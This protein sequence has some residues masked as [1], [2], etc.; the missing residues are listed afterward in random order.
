ME[1]KDIK[2]KVVDKKDIKGLLEHD[3]VQSFIASSKKLYSQI[4]KYCD[5]NETISS[6]IIKVRQ[7]TKRHKKKI[8]SVIV[9]LLAIFITVNYIVPLK[10][11]ASKRQ[12]T[13]RTDVWKLGTVDFV[14][15]LAVMGLVRGGESVDVGFQVAGMLN[16]V[17]V[18]EGQMVNKGDL[19]VTLDPTDARLKVEYNES[20]LKAAQ[21]RVEVHEQLFKLKNI[22]A[23]KLDEVK[24]EYE[25]QLK[26]LEFAR[27]E[28]EKTRLIAPVSGLVGPIEVEPGELVTPNTKVSSLYNVSHV[29]VDLGIIEKDIGKI[30]IGQKIR[31]SV[32]A[33]PDVI[34][35]GKLITISP[36][37]EGKSRNFKV[38]AKLDNKNTS[39][40][41][42]PGMFVRA[43]LEVFSAEKSLVIPVTALK[44]NKVYVLVDGKA[45]A[46]EVKIVYRSY[47]YVVIESGLG[48]G[49]VIVAELEGDFSDEPKIEIINEREYES[50]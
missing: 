26:E 20:K 10:S 36:V 48:A 21:K 16:E 25:S 19:L 45:K 29:Y 23:A 39:A 13:V 32:D 6:F 33:Y 8:V 22:I 1:D 17:L 27:R 40:L 49:D 50:S 7:I 3:K 31:A 46:K 38:T 44:E 43:N 11:V 2:K 47:D 14:D 30:S 5:N 24:Y 15:N 41:F 35:D 4:K 34:K 28:L 12:R 9:L 18:H 37:I 42:L